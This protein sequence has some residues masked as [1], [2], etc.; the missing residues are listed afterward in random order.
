[1]PNRSKPLAALSNILAIIGG[2]KTA[3]SLTRRRGRKMGANVYV[4]SMFGLV[5][6]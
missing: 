5:C 1:M 3:P 4:M 2:R 6:G